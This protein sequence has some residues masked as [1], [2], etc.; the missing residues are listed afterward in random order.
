MS[1]LAYQTLLRI[2][3]GTALFEELA[4]RGVLHGVWSRA[5]GERRAI[6][7]GSVAFGLWHVTQTVELLGGSGLFPTSV[8][9]GLGVLGGVMAASVGGLFFSFVRLRTGSVYAPFLTHWLINAVGAIA[10]FLVAL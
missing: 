8:L 10:A 5:A 6:I 3:L 1:A 4:F 7:G 9:L 2:P